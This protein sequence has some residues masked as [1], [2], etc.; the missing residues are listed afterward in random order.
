MCIGH[1][2]SVKDWY[3]LLGN[4]TNLISAGFVLKP[5]SPGAIESRSTLAT[6]AKLRQ[7]VITAT[8]PAHLIF[9]PALKALR[10]V[11]Y[12][13]SN[14]F[15]TLADFLQV[16]PALTELHFDTNIFTFFSFNIFPQ[17]ACVPHLLLP[18][19]ERLVFENT[20]ADYARA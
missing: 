4:R 11:G 18:N 6:H 10:L 9:F 3:E 2:I 5:D 7:L 8:P 17:S 13:K 14:S 19:L 1:E 16:T 12:K 15:R 20:K